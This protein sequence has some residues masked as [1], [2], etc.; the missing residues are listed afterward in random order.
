[1]A[2]DSTRATLGDLPSVQRVRRLL[3]YRFGQIAFEPRILIALGVREAGRI[4]PDFETEVRNVGL[5]VI[6]EVGRLLDRIDDLG[7]EYD[8]PDQFRIHCAY[9]EYLFIRGRPPILRELLRREWEL[10]VLPHLNHRAK[11]MEPEDLSIYLGKLFNGENRLPDELGRKGP[12]DTSMRRNQIQEMG[13]VLLSGNEL[14]RYRRLFRE[15]GGLQNPPT[16]DHFVASARRDRV[17]GSHL[18]LEKSLRESPLVELIETMAAPFD[19]HPYQRWIQSFEMNSKML[20]DR[21]ASL[22]GTSTAETSTTLSLYQLFFRLGVELEILIEGSEPTAGLFPDPHG[23]CAVR[24]LLH[25]L[26]ADRMKIPGFADLWLDGGDAFTI[27]CMFSNLSREHRELLEKLV[28]VIGEHGG[29][30]HAEHSIDKIAEKFPPLGLLAD[31]FEPVFQG[32]EPMI[33]W[34]ALHDPSLHEKG[35]GSTADFL[36][37]SP[38]S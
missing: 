31:A 32:R 30:A 23:Q 16:L 5:G 25:R 18:P 14:P 6:G 2:D 17:L 24:E 29:M 27:L 10:Y 11:G 37:F 13:L 3:F 21:L 28:S 35:G 7:S 12:A 4:T 9:L 33:F 20:P 38:S 19:L 22:P 15:L 8:R 36:S 34:H 26:A 1:M